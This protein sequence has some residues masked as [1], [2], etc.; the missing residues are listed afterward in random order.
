MNK[1]QCKNAANLWR[2]LLTLFICVFT[3]LICNTATCF[4][5]RLAGGLAFAA[6]AVLSALAK[7]FCLKCFDMLHD[8]YRSFL[9]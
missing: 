2:H 6:S 5:G 1:K 4:A 3:L 7:V 8:H 9:D